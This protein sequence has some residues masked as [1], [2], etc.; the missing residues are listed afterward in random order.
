MKVL[1]TF[2]VL[3]C[4]TPEQKLLPMALPGQKSVNG[5]RTRQEGRGRGARRSSSSA[6]FEL[7]RSRE[8]FITV[9]IVPL[10]TPW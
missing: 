6:E 9:R 8:G 4:F 10:V 7:E 1:G 2:G 5:A 3:P